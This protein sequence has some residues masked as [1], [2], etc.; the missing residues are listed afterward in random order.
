MI[1]ERGYFNN[2]RVESSIINESLREIRTFSA[3]SE[4]TNKPTVFL[5]H[6]HDD[7]E[8]LK[9]V[10][11]LLEKY[12]A[13]IYIDSMDNKMPKETSGDTAKR[14][15]EVIK[16]CRKFVLLA[17]DKAI[18]SYWCNWELGFGDTHKYINNIAILSMKEKG[19]YDWKYAGNEYLQIYPSIE[20]RDGN[21]FYKSGDLISKGYYVRTP[22]GETYN[23]TPLKDWLNR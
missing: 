20:Y 21:S 14:I 12:G 15:K 7:L 9:G 5:S 16:F 19:T 3:S 1:F 11:G 8:D 22:I 13:K 17:T 10:M 18:E 6:K 23:I 4:Y 2:T